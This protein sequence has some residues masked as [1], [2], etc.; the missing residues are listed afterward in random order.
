MKTLTLSFASLILAT[1]VSLASFGLFG[2]EKAS[3]LSLYIGATDNYE[4]KQHYYDMTQSKFGA[5]PLEYVAYSNFIGLN[6]GFVH[7][8]V[9][10]KL[11]FDVRGIQAELLAGLNQDIYGLC[12]NGIFGTAN[13]VYGLQSSLL[14]NS[15]VQVRGFQ[16]TLGLNVADDISGMQASLLANHGD[17][18][19]LQ[20][21]ILFNGTSDS[22]EFAGCQIGLFNYAKRLYGFQIGLLNYNAAGL[23]LPLINAG[24]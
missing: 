21:A 11:D 6:V 23:L 8:S 1:S 17:G 9:R 12:A 13:G 24:W 4:T 2:P 15:A 3:S 14:F 7:D 19:G 16:A 20:A 5:E 22:G 18:F 10:E